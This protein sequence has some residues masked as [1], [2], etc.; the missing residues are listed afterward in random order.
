MAWRRD[1]NL[2]KKGDASS[3]SSET[4]SSRDSKQK[5]EQQ[6]EGRSAAIATKFDPAIQNEIPHRVFAPRPAYIR[7]RDELEA[8]LNR[9][10]TF[11]ADEL[12]YL[13]EEH[14]TNH[15]INTYA[16]KREIAKWVNGELRHFGV[17]IKCP[18]TGRPSALIADPS[19]SEGRFQLLNKTPEGRKVRS[20]SSKKL[21]PLELIP[22]NAT[23]KSVDVINKFSNVDLLITPDEAEFVSKGNPAGKPATLTTNVAGL[24]EE[25]PEDFEGRKAALTA[26][27][28]AFRQELANQFAPALNAKAQAMPH[29]SYE[30]KKALARWVNEELRRFDLA[31]KCPKTGE[32]SILTVDPG[33][34][35]EIGRFSIEH[36]T[37]DGKRHRSLTSPALPE[38]ELT[39]A[40]PRREALREWQNRVSQ[41]G[42]GA[43]RA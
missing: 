20:L 4:G 25:M 34:H 17:A 35:P 21:P 40:P 10:K 26:V 23:E 14:L 38:L 3:I 7:G 28:A 12:S 19:G 6:S 29:G 31:I 42:G 39:E 18:K 30:E 9:E 16:D 8:S 36:K 33:H 43:S 41:Q 13:L 1:R 32:P 24:F 11:I 37:P 27:N 2:E 22:T 5:K 15:E